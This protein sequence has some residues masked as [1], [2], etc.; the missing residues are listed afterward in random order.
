M[1]SLREEIWLRPSMGT[2]CRCSA[3]DERFHELFQDHGPAMPRAPVSAIS[4]CYLDSLLRT[5]VP[6]WLRA[7]LQ[8]EKARRTAR[9]QA[10]LPARIMRLLQR[11]ANRL[12]ARR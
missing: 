7:R 5:S 1:Q 3:E 6:D 2:A 11:L 8:F 4:D 10:R 9:E 12:E